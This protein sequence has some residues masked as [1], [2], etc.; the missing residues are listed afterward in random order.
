MRL[1]YDPEADAVYIWLRELPYAFGEDL[2]HE[3]RV[4]YAADMKPIGI[5]LLDVSKGVNLDDLPQRHDVERLLE[6]HH[7]RVYA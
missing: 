1:E 6:Q 2:D 5:E 7:I 4:D 3:R